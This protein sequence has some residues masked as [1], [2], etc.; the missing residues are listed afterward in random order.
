MSKKIFDILNWAGPD[1]SSPEKEPENPGYETAGAA[2]KKELT[3]QDI[4]NYVTEHFKTQ[5]LK[6][7][8]QNVITFPM[9]FSVILN[10]SDYEEFKYYCKVVSEAVVLDFY[11]IIKEALNEDKQKVC[12]NLAKYWNISFLQCDDEPLDVNDNIVQVDK[13]EYYIFSTVLDKLVDEVE[14]SGEGG[15]TF[16]VSKGGSQLYAN[17][18]INKDT[19]SDM[20]LIGETHVHIDWDEHLTSAYVFDSMPETDTGK[21]VAKIRTQGKVFKMGNG[22]YTI[23]GNRETRRDKNIF[24]VDSDFVENGHVQIF[25]KDDNKFQIQ[26]LHDSVMV[27]DEPVEVST[28]NDKIFKNLA[29]GDTISIFNNEVLM[30]FSTIK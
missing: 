6:K 14:K 2:K 11:R 19:L 18:N 16:A 21:A 26:A 10:K 29:D 17:M 15:S 3:N 28:T 13:G 7:S 25:I 1:G 30:E 20:K 4:F 9:S 8:F 5:M 22:T 12:K 27:N 24:R 23:S